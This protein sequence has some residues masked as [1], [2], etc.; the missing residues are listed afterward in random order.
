MKYTNLITFGIGQSIVRGALNVLV[1]FVL[2]LIHATFHKKHKILIIT[3]IIFGSYRNGGTKWGSLILISEH[4][5]T[6]NKKERK[7]L[8]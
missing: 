2:S 6:K 4:S 7:I 3:G 8:N 5:G 1:C